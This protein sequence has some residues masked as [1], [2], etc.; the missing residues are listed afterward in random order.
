MASKIYT[1]T[2]PF[3]LVSFTSYYKVFTPGAT[4]VCGNCEQEF[5]LADT[6]EEEA[7][8]ILEAKK[9]GAKRGA[10]T[11]VRLMAHGE[12]GTVFCIKNG[13]A[14]SI[15]DDL[16]D[17]IL[18]GAQQSYPEARLWYEDEES[19]SASYLSMLMNELD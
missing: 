17:L 16:L 7:E 5:E 10:A 3:C 12:D 1:V 2:C 9:E 8:R 15:G 4:E 14:K 11:H 19:T 6:E 13:I 18:T